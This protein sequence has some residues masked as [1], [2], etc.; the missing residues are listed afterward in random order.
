MDET[1]NK[2]DDNE[3]IQKSGWIDDD[4]Q[5]KLVKKKENEDHQDPNWRVN[6]IFEFMTSRIR[7]N[8]KNIDIQY[9]I[10]Q[11]FAAI[12]IKFSPYD[13]KLYDYYIITAVVYMLKEK[14][15]PHL[16]IELRREY[17]IIEGR[18]DEIELNLRQEHKLKV[19]DECMDLCQDIISQLKQKI[20]DSLFLQKFYQIK[21]DKKVQRRRRQ[22]Q[23]RKR[24]DRKRKYQE[25]QEQREYYKSQYNESMEDMQSNDID[26][27][28]DDNNDNMEPLN[29]KRKLNNDNDSTENRSDWVSFLWS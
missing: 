9:C 15:S 23:R 10:L 18:E 21:S 25:I 19:Y 11:W 1:E 20:G 24:D 3:E 27:F 16:S 22:R 17:L 29:K 6:K 5:S 8:D 4:L 2:D 26:G 12:V 28:I 13:L 7:E 14:T